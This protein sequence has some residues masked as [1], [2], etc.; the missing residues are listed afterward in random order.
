MPKGKLLS[1]IQRAALTALPRA[2]EEILIG[3]YY[4]FS[5]QDLA[6]IRKQ[7]GA[8]N[9]LG[10]AIQLCYWRYPG[11]KW[12]YQESV[13][14]HILVYVAQQLGHEPHNIEAYAIGQK[15]S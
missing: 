4:T 8:E 7:R 15:L 14:E 13:P 1:N 6:A 9:Q 2:N 5:E 3:Q 12:E 11:R 10:F